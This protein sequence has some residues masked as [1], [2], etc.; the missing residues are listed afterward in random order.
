[1]RWSGA[2]ATNCTCTSTMCNFNTISQQINH[3]IMSTVSSLALHCGPLRWR[4]GE[5]APSHCAAWVWFEF[6]PVP[7]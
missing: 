1:V 3:M 2:T 4:A 5:Q 7:V 6:T